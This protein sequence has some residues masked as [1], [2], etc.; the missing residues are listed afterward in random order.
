MTFVVLGI[1]IFKLPIQYSSDPSVFFQS[2]EYKH[3][4][5]AKVSHFPLADISIQ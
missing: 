3:G 4:C 2:E 5:I 1:G